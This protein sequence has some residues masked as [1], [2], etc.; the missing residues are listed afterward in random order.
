MS[1]YSPGWL[2]PRSIEGPFTLIAPLDFQKITIGEEPHFFDSM[3][4]GWQ[5]YYEVAK[6]QHAQ[7]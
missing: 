6:E 4:M 5:F 7:D 1:Q 3:E 2:D